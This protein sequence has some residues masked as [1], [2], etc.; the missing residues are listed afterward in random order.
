MRCPRSSAFPRPTVTWPGSRLR[1]HVHGHQGILLSVGDKV[2]RC[3]GLGTKE[4]EG[5]AGGPTSAS[6]ECIVG[7]QERVEVTPHLAGTEKMGDSSGVSPSFI[8]AALL[9]YNSPLVS[10][11]HFKCTLH[12]LVGHSQSCVTATTI[13]FRTFSSTHPRNQAHL[14]SPSIAPQLVPCLRVHSSDL[15]LWACRPRHPWSPSW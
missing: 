3:V 2:W 14:K 6:G 10:S 4:G 9:R 15:S 1:T 5:C 7:K 8:I 12:W 13:H 11:T